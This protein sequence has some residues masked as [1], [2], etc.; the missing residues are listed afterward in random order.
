MKPS[1]ISLRRRQL[2]MAGMAAPVALFASRCGAAGNALVAELVATA[3]GGAETLLVS[4]RILGA[5]GKPLSGVL[6][7][8]LHENTNEVIGV[9]TD[10]DGRF[11]FTTTAP[12]GSSGLPR[13]VRY[14]VSHDG[15][16][17]PV[18]HLISDDLVANLRRDDGGEWRTTFGLTLA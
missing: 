10:A 2:M 15:H 1:T 8:A 7:E 11:M 14:R 16:Q 13:P 5:N 4:G 9:N 18:T 12:I 17:T 3:G 6:V